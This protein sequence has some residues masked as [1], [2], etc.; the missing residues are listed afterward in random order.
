MLTLASVAGAS[1]AAP[2]VHRAT[3][4]TEATIP[5]GNPGLPRTALEADARDNGHTAQAPYI[6]W[7]GIAAV[8]LVGGGG[9][10]FKRWYDH[11]NPSTDRSGD[12]APLRDRAYATAAVG[13]GQGRG[14]PG[15]EAPGEALDDPV[16]ALAGLQHDAGVG[17]GAGVAEGAEQG[18][19][20][21]HTR[22]VAPR[23]DL[24]DTS[25]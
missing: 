18:G 14:T 3:A 13:G 11:E 24:G 8:V 23:C 7:S 1:A 9:L 4:T 16:L 21:G 5:G 19:E 12:L 22:T 6:I 25:A 15:L 17:L 20:P 10:L 2:V